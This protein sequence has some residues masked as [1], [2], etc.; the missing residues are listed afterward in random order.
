MRLI[1]SKNNNIIIK[2]PNKKLTFIKKKK[3]KPKISQ[4]LHKKV[5]NKVKLS[6]YYEDF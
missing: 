2:F 3:K 6:I 5:T 1:I 4:H